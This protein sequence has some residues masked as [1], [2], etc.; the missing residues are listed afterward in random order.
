MKL[1]LLFTIIFFLLGCK[2]IFTTSAFSSFK[3]DVSDMSTDELVAY[4]STTPL[5]DIPAEDLAIAE[6]ALDESRVELTDAEKADPSLNPVLAA[7]YVEESVQLLAINMEQADVEGLISD[8]LAEPEEGEESLDFVDSLLADTERLDNMEEA[9]EYAVD[10]FLVDPES[11]TST[12]LVVGSVGLISDVIQ[13]SAKSDALSD[14]TE[15]EPEDFEA[16]LEAAVNDDGDPVFTAEEIADI[17]TAQLMLEAAERGIGEDS[18]MAG[19]FE[20]LPI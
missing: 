17:Q 20:G 10:A 6:I 13:D 7:Q 18:P 5:S 19:L 1:I 9:S 12:E 8:L 16:A 15:A 2:N 14:I 3:K 11:L 4:I